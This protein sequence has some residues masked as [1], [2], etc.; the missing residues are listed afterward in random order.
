MLSKVAKPHF[1]Y[2]FSRFKVQRNK[3]ST[4]RIAMWKELRIP[5]V[6]TMEASFCGPKPEFNE[7]TKQMDGNYHYNTEDLKDLGKNLCETLLLYCEG[8]LNLID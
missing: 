5:N 4:S 8:D 6:F 3:E 2:D 1:S 7:L